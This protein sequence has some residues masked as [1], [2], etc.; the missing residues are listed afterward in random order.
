MGSNVIPLT[1][2]LNRTPTT[3]RA[4][5]APVLPIGSCAVY[6]VTEA[7]ELLSL[8]RGSAYTLVRNGQIPALKLG[9]RWIIPKRRFHTWLD[10]LPT[11]DVEDIDKELAA[12]ERADRRA[13]R[14]GA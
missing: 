14:N 2:R 11:A 3:D 1:P 9:G 10:N 5:P 4:T 12:L 6:T 8:S 13:H 7:A